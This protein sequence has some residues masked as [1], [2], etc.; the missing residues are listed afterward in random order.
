MPCKAF[1]ARSGVFYMLKPTNT[2]SG[3][4]VLTGLISV[5]GSLISIALETFFHWLKRGLICCYL[6]LD[7]VAW[8][9]VPYIPLWRIFR[10]K[11]FE[12]ISSPCRTDRIT[13]VFWHISTL[14]KTFYFFIFRCK[15][16]STRTLGITRYKYCTKGTH[17]RCYPASFG[18]FFLFRSNLPRIN[19]FKV[20]QFALLFVPWVELDE[21]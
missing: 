18:T 19:L 11:Y 9:R 14:S 5:T 13:I 8:R 1:T 12:S 10:V 20:K 3:R 2:C 6:T 4:T 21:H 15:Q 16:I 17:R 7:K